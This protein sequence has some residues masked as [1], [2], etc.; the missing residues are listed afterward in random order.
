MTA[1]AKVLEWVEQHFEIE[2]ITVEPFGILPGGHLITDRN[3]QTMLVWWDILK[4]Q[5]DYDMR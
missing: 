2:H 1:T 3:G 5:I 4:E